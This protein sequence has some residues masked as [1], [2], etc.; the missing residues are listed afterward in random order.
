MSLF[1]TGIN[2]IYFIQLLWGLTWKKAQENSWQ[3]ITQKLSQCC[4]PVISTLGRLWFSLGP[5]WLQLLW[6]PVVIILTALFYPN[7]HPGWVDKLHSYSIN[8]P[9]HAIQP[10]ASGAD[11]TSGKMTAG[12]LIS[13]LDNSSRGSKSSWY[14]ESHHPREVYMAP[15]ILAIL[16]LMGI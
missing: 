12:D 13:K 14:S 7:W 8:E 9:W 2:N 6:L 16:T 11:L 1:V 15:T 10:A 5:P 4:V 3:N